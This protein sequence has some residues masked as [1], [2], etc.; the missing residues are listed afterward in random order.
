LLVLCRR[1]IV[2]RTFGWLGLYRRLSKDCKESTKT[3][4]AMMYVES[5]RKMYAKKSALVLLLACAALLGCAP[6]IQNQDVATGLL[7]IS[8]T[9]APPDLNVE[10]A[11]VT[12]SSVQVHLAGEEEAPDK[13]TEAGWFTA[14]E[15]AQTF[16]LI[17][18]RDTEAFLGSAEL[19]PGKYTQIRL[20]VDEAVA[21]I[22]GAEH[23][24]K[25]PSGRIKLVHPFTIEVGR[26]TKLTLDFDAQKS[27]HAAGKKYMMRPTI[28]V[29][30]EG[31]TE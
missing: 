21:T 29:I 2:E 27:I 31:P 3:S 20:S 1:W 17:A 26:T 11:L 24:L 10:K 23:S 5:E 25:V 6:Q 4:E 8:L 18:L 28:K 22:D 7:E 30:V 16:D 15:A 9:D 13:E 12:I 14:V 19:E